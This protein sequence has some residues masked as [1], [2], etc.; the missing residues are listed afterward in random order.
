MDVT[1]SVVPRALSLLQYTEYT[2]PTDSHVYE[3]MRAHTRS[4]SVGQ[5]CQ[6][7]VTNDSDVGLMCDEFV[8]HDI[9]Q[10]MTRC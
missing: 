4:R 9:W 1:S 3:H 8:I 5:R 10:T 6:K 7:D 2:D